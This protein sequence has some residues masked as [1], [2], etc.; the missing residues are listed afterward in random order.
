MDTLRNP[1]TYFYTCAHIYIH[2]PKPF[3]LSV[4]KKSKQ[5]G[6]DSQKQKITYFPL[7]RRGTTDSFL[8]LLLCLKEEI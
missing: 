1:H 2:S 3:L 8:I 4:E 7:Q 5:L 6:M